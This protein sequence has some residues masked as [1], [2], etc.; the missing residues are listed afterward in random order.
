[1]IFGLIIKSMIFFRRSN[2]GQNVL[3]P[4]CRIW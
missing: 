4:I 3:V 2:T 1:L